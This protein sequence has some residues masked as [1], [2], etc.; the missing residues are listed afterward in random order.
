MLPAAKTFADVTPAG[1]L[2]DAELPPFSAPARESAYDFKVLVYCSRQAATRRRLGRSL[3][4]QVELGHVYEI[5]RGVVRRT[6]REFSIFEPGAAERAINERLADKLSGAA[7]RSDRFLV[8]RWAARAEV[9]LPDEVLAL[10]RKTLGE[11]YEIKTRA[12][13]GALRMTTV[14]EL[15][16]GW[17]RF[18]NDVA[19][20][21]NARHAVQL[22]EDP[23]NIAQVLEQILQGRQDEAENLL[24]LIDRIVQAHLSADILDLAVNSETVLRQTLKMLGIPL[25]ETTASSLLAPLEDDA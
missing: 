7:V 21:R 20:S 3:A 24:T 13:T 23:Q 16:L 1:T 14:D 22:A 25:P 15:R 12:T 11:E 8:S 17:D 5:V 4:Y 18:L 9:T 2:S 19:Q 10:M 6:A